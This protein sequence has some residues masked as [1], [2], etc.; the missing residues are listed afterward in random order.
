VLAFSS[1]AAGPLLE[2]ENGFVHRRHGYRIGAPP[3]TGVTWERIEVEG[4]ALAYRRVGPVRMTLS[5]RCKA[6]LTRAEVLA[7][8][9]RIGIGDHTLRE[10]GAVAVGGLSGWAQIFDVLEHDAL[11][12]VKTVT[13]IAGPCVLDWVLTARDGH[14]FEAAKGDFDAWWHTLRFEAS[15]DEDATESEDAT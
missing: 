15:A 6:P 4:S 11:V 10:G 1:C 8:H 14:G 12:R 5:S 9:L 7:R 2:T 3:G 13:L